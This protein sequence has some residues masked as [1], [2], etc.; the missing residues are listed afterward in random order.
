[1][2]DFAIKVENLSKGFLIG[3]KESQKENLL[4][5]LFHLVKSPINNYR[6]IKKLGNI[7]STDNSNEIFW[8][9]KNLNFTIEKGDAVA[10]IGKNGAGKSTLL[11]VLSQITYPTVGK[12]I[13]RGRTSSLL[14]VGTGF[15][16]E[17][18]G[19]EN[20]Y[21]NGS[22]LGMRRKEIDAKFDQIV[23][24]SGVRKFIDT[25]V[26]RYSSGMLVRLAFAVAAHLEPEILIVDE[27][28][29]VGDAEFQKKCLGKM[30][31][32]AS[33]GRTILFVSHN[34]AA[35]Q[36]LCQ[37][38]IVLFNG[39]ITFAGTITEAV[40]HYLSQFVT[41]SRMVKYEPIDAPGN[42]K[43]KLIE[44]YVKAEMGSHNDPIYSG[45]SIEIFFSMLIDP[46]ELKGSLDLTFHLYD[47]LGVLIFVGATGQ[48]EITSGLFRGKT[49]CIIP[50]E[51]M[52]EG[53]YTIT[54][55]LLVKDKGYILTEV[56]DVLN[57]DVLPK[58]SGQLGWQGKKEG[59]V[60]PKL[61][62]NLIEN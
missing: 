37:K 50:E 44:A 12:A 46:N 8:A 24:F 9:L 26:K 33:E 10:I 39:E 56:K 20:V 30:K 52:H 38:G 54:S 61:D 23:D 27:V 6:K 62:W 3:L 1:M 25:P 41:E 13:I 35:V 21:L 18:T 55:V 40:H 36:N 45:Q 57:F 43:A 19:R 11:K 15:N 48:S 31:N 49:R 42:S 59:A 4:S 5:A 22:I 53:S 17:L 34:L 2:E 16:E 7:K 29:A 51:L 32:V 47:E 28:L 14:E 58:R 60:K